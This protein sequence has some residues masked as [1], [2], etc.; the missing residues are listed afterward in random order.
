MAAGDRGAARPVRGE[1]KVF[2]EL[3]GR[4]LVAWVVSCLQRVP[5]V[6]EVW[7][8]GD[9]QRLE[10]ALGGPELQGEL[11]KPLHLIPQFGNLYENLW[12]SYRRVLPGAPEEGRDPLP[13]DADQPVLYLSGDLPFATPQEISQFARRSLETGADYALGLV[14]AESMGAFHPVAPGKPGIQMASF[15]LREGRFRQSNL[16]LVKPARLAHRSLIQQMYE[17]RHQRELRD[18]VELA[19]RLLRHGGLA[20]LWYFLL[21][22]AAGLVDRRGWRRVANWL[23]RLVP[24]ARV[25]RGCGDL[26]GTN[27][28]FVVTEVGGCAIDIDTESDFEASRERFQEWRAAQAERAARLVGALPL[29][30]GAREAGGR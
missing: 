6:S 18:V 8:V 1:S 10:D 29:A 23:R 4:S 22:H 11:V 30:A 14:T 21:M 13:G 17:A 9:A 20:V 15:N 2:L 12:E 19:A 26:L 3:A 27:F 25:A 28:Q 16:H 24:L 7:V 5:E